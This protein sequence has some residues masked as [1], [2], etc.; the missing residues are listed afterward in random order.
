MVSLRQIRLSVRSNLVSNDDLD[1]TFSIRAAATSTDQTF[2]V[3]EPGTPMSLLAG[4]RLER[5][6]EEKIFVFHRCCF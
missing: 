3:R 5:R 2:K 1:R 6:R 4:N